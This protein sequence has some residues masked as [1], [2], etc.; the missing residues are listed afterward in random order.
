[1]SGDKLISIREK[2]RQSFIFIF[3]TWTESPGLYKTVLGIIEFLF[4][5]HGVGLNSSHLQNWL[6]SRRKGVKTNWKEIE[7]QK[8]LAPSWEQGSDE[9]S[10]QNLGSFHVCDLDV[11]SKGMG[12]RTLCEKQPIFCTTL[13]RKPMQASKFDGNFDQQFAN[14]VC[15]TVFTSRSFRNGT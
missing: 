5:F 1:M 6:I 3:E 7:Y 14:E 12:Q 10:V 2:H 11:T 13:C 15:H 4:R 8:S 9:Q